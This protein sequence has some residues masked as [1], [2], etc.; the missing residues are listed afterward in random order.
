MVVVIYKSFLVT[1]YTLTSEILL[2]F[3]IRSSLVNLN[4]LPLWTNELQ[5]LVIQLRVIGR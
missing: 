5:L 2:V 1:D 3:I 4:K